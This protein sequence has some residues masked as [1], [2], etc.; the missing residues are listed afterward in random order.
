M[1]ALLII[2][3]LPEEAD[4]LFA[5]QGVPVATA[6]FAARRVGDITIV[7]SGL[8]KVNAATAAALWAE[9]TQ[10]AT[11]LMSGTCG[12]MSDVSGD[13]FWLAE[14]VQHDYGAARPGG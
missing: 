3:A 1:S 8:G 9:R 10:P 6:P 5:G 14:A 7:T 12:R 11:L 13:A 4:A 2:A